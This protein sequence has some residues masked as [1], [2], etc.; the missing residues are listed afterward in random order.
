MFFLFLLGMFSCFNNSVIIVFSRCPLSPSI[1]VYSPRVLLVYVYDAHADCRK[2]V[3]GAFL[4]LYGVALAIEGWGVVASLKIYPPSAGAASS[5]ITL[6]VAFGFALSRPCLTLELQ[7]CVLCMLL[8]SGRVIGE[9]IELGYNHQSG[10]EV[11][12]VFVADSESDFETT[13]GNLFE[14]KTE[15][16]M[17]TLK[18]LA[19]PDLNVQPLAITYTELEKHLKLNSGFINLLPKFHGLLP[20]DR[21]NVDAASGGALVNKTPTQARELF[22]LIAQNTQQFGTRET[23]VKKVNELESKSIEQKLSELTCMMSKLVSGGGNVRGIHC[24]VCC[25]EGHATD[26]CPTHSHKIRSQSRDFRIA[27]DVI[28]SNLQ[29]QMNQRIPSQPF[30]NPKENIKAVVLRNKKQLPEP[31]GR[32]RVESEKEVPKVVNLELAKTT[33][34]SSHGAETVRETPGNDNSDQGER[35]EDMVRPKAPFP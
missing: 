24:G 19:A 2:N 35:V 20:T 17:A 26:A 13:F 1:V 23:L 8:R 6:V 3:S 25:L 10:C 31:K 22:N 32:D 4:L 34:S 9:I 7:L 33:D 5:A 21:N 30:P 29:A 14:V 18:E 27:T 12:N 16:K 28:I 15:Q 11:S